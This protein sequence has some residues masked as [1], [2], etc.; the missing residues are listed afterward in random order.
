[1][2][3]VAQCC[4]Y[5]LTL[6]LSKKGTFVQNV[7]KIRLNEGEKRGTSVQNVHIFLKVFL[8]RGFPLEKDS[9]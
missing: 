7:H 8:Q 5:T 4:S 2:S 1:M 6:E 9:K 3:R